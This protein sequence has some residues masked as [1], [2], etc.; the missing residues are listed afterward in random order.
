CT[1]FDATEHIVYATAE[2]LSIDF[3]NGILAME[4]AAP[5]PGE[6]ILQLARKP[7]GPFLAAGRPTNFDWDSQ[8]LRARLKIPAGKF[9]D[10]HVRIGIAIEAPDTSAFFNEA[11]R[12]VTGRTNTVSTMYS[13][14]DV[15]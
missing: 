13:S 6:V 2:L 1:N 15:A 5:E 12:L 10:K 7:V 14:E 8:T 4:F 9:A 3:E 11:K